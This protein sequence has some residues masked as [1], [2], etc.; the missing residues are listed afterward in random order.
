MSL[1][2]QSIQEN[3]FGNISKAGV[4]EGIMKYPSKYD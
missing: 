1:A 2:E 4:W 3:I